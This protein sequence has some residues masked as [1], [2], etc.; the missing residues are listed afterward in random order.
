MQKSVGRRTLGVL[1]PLALFASVLGGTAAPASA[2]SVAQVVSDC[3]NPRWVQ[4][5]DLVFPDPECDLK[6]T[7]TPVKE[8]SAPERKTDPHYQ[9][10]SAGSTSF[11]NGYSKST[12]FSI[13]LDFGLK[14]KIGSDYDAQ[15][16]AKIGW[17]W[18]W[19]QSYSQT[20]STTVPAYSFGWIE[21]RTWMWRSNVDIRAQYDS[22]TVETVNS[23]L[24]SPVKNEP[25]V[26]TGRSRPMTSVEREDLCPGA[27]AAPWI[28]TVA[29][30]KPAVKTYA[31]DPRIWTLQN[32]ALR[33]S[34]TK[35][36]IDM[37][38]G[39][40]SAGN[41]VIQW[42]CESGNQRQV[43]RTLHR[44]GGQYQIYNKTADKCMA[45]DNWSGSNG[46]KVIN[47]HC[48]STEQHYK[49][50]PVT[51]TPNYGGK[52]TGYVLRNA[53]TNKCLA[54]DSAAGSAGNAQI[55]QYTCWW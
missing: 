37:R 4:Y 20:H 36:C 5:G 21:A 12:S 2:A 19:S 11:T 10:E 47:W 55:K 8:L 29:G 48:A 6:V 40:Y 44:S 52:T 28:G 16:G 46:A 41:D 3:L 49:I 25:P 18:S 45:V 39:S 24:L 30:G 17:T 14:G 53:S 31:A 15:M 23:D 38:N 1:L 26:F 13:G 9:C 42:N 50:Y 27:P 51:V 22:G 35:M 54:P 43:W 33:N 34:K 32:G 7:N